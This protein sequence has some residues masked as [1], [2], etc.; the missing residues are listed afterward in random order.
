[1]RMETP[2]RRVTRVTTVRPPGWDC[3]RPHR[4]PLLTP[5]PP[6]PAPR[7][8][9]EPA[10]L[11]P[12][13]R[14]RLCPISCEGHCYHGNSVPAAGGLGWLLGC[15]PSRTKAGVRCAVCWRQAAPEGGMQDSAGAGNCCERG[16][17]G[18]SELC[19]PSGEGSF[20]LKKRQDSVAVKTLPCS[21]P[22]E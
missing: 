16:G 8:Q 18:V 9:W 6:P 2:H 12:G 14:R 17:D 21:L 4:A 15:S 20:G 19:A 1:M 11:L 10:S 7:T 13:Q 3:I 5:P 22:E